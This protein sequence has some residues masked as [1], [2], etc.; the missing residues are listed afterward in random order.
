M[1]LDVAA[2]RERRL[3]QVC[4]DGL[5]LAFSLAADRTFTFGAFAA[6]AAFI[7]LTLLRESPL[8]KR[9]EVTAATVPVRAEAVEPAD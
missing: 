1:L 3:T 5:S 7:T 6:I 4:V 2:R 8:K 9:T